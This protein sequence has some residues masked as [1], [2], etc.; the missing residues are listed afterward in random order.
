MDS[1]I[2]FGH[3]AF[4][5]VVAYLVAAVVLGVVLGA[6]IGG[7]DALQRWVDKNGWDE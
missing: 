7:M 1:V 5:L 6:F 2:Q 3:N 4:G